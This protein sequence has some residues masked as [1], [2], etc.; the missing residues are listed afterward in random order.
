M[1]LFK[2]VI[3]EESLEDKS[4]LKKIKIVSTNVE[5]VVKKHKTPWI[6]KWTL[7][8]VE[9]PEKQVDKI[10]GQISKSLDS[11]HDWYAD[12]KNDKIHYIIYKNRVFKIDCKSQEQ[13]DPAKA[14]GIS[15][16]IPE[17]QVNFSPEVS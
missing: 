9:I 10:A 16:G 6:K 5:E 3:I 7:H 2:G 13:Y 14:Y 17:Y 15:L 4:V 12:F 1:G 11:K 8:N